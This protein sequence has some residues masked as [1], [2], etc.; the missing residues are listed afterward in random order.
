MQVTM[1]VLSKNQ[2]ES[3]IPNNNNGELEIEMKNKVK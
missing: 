1:K 3:N 2:N